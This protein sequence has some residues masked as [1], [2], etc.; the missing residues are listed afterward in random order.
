MQ[1]QFVCAKAIECY[2]LLY[3]RTIRP[4]G[5]HL[6]KLHERV[7]LKVR[8]FKKTLSLVLSVLMVVSCCSALFS[9]FASAYTTNDGASANYGVYTYDFGTKDATGKTAS[10]ITDDDDEKKETN[11]GDASLP[12]VIESDPV[13]Y[14]KYVGDWAFSGRVPGPMTKAPS[15][16]WIESAGAE[17]YV[18][19]NPDIINGGQVRVSV[20]LLYWEKGHV[21]D[22]KYTV[23]HNGKVD[24]FHL[25]PAALKENE[26]Q[27]LGTFDFEG[28]GKDYVRL[29]CTGKAGNTR[30]STL[31]FEIM[32]EQNNSV[33]QTLYVTPT[34][35]ELK[36]LLAPVAGNL[37]YIKTRDSFSTYND[38]GNSWSGGN[39]NM[40]QPGGMYKMYAAKEA[41]FPVIGLGVDL[42]QHNVPIMRGWN[43]IGFAS[44]VGMTVADAFALLSPEDGDIVK[45]QFDFAIYDGYAWEGTLQALVPGEGYIYYSDYASQLCQ[46]S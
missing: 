6:R 35:P 11:F 17:T 7:F 23:H 46:I 2:A 41:S 44:P 42:K 9:T 30:A 5:I 10:T 22:V 29:E 8:N 13:G 20:Y 37:T 36:S 25:N 33:W 15:S 19:Y 34:Q 24:E 18:E 4:A 16:L 12:H 21:D 14:C 27:T 3:Y 1:G 28:G 40:L 38:A 31:A 43:W 39:F 32:N 26:W 45:N